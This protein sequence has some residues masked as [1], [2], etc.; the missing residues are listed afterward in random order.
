[1][2]LN[3]IFIQIQWILIAITGIFLFMNWNGNVI[4]FMVWG[5]AIL[6]NALWMR[7]KRITNIEYAYS[8]LLKR[9]PYIWIAIRVILIFIMC[10][11]VILDCNIFKFLD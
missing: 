3:H 1:M 10:L 7:D 8:R 4:V 2:K 9:Y 11:Y 5:L 6:C